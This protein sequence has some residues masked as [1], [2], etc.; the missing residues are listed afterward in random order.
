MRVCLVLAVFC[1]IVSIIQIDAKK[2]PSKGKGKGGK[3]KGGQSNEETTAT[4]ECPCNMLTECQPRDL[5]IDHAME[6]IRVGM[7]KANEVETPVSICIKDRHDNLVAHVR[8]E[9][10]M[11]GTVDLSCQKAKSSAL[12]PFPSAGLQGLPGIELSNGIISNLGGGLPLYTA[13]GVSIGSIGVSG[14]S[15]GEADEVIAQVAVDIIDSI[16]AS[17]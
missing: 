14:A 2:K 12:F 4:G 6:M 11:L 9:N 3:G 17:N 7:E 16:L 5:N 15:T 8:M 1:L 13:S 10:A